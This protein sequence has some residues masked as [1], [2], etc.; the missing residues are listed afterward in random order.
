VNKEE[1][2]ARFKRATPVQAAILGEKPV[3][4]KKKKK[5]KPN[6]P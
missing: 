1:L 3:G 5:R 4:L 2:I 6:H